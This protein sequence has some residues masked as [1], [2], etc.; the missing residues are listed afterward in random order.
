M[1][2]D[3]YAICEATQKYCYLGEFYEGDVSDEHQIKQ[4]ME[5]EIHQDRLNNGV[6]VMY[7]LR[8]CAFMRRHQ[9]YGIRVVGENELWDM[10]DADPQYQWIEDQLN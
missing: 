4:R 8:L 5:S 7:L 9:Q 10:Q 6:G 1:A 3:H 2:N